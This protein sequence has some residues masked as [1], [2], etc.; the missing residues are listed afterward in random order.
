MPVR[1]GILG[2]GSIARAAHLRSLGRNA[3]A[4]VVAI[5]DADPGNLA[6]A[7]PLAPN[8]RVAA[9][10]AEVLEMPEVDA[11]IVALPPA[12]HADA[13]LVAIE[14]QKHLY[15]EKPLATSTTDAA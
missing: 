11:V 8:A 14:R 5:A 10:Y 13:S 3:N 12:L 7:R 15:V 2:C 6:A 9:D 4:I 1:L